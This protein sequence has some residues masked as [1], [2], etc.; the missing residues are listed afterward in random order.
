MGVGLT[1]LLRADQHLP[2]FIA[3]FAVDVIFI[4][5]Q[6]ANLLRLGLIASVCMDMA[7]GFCQRAGQLPPVL[8]ACVGMG[9]LPCHGLPPFRCHTF[10]SVKCILDC[11]SL[12]YFDRI[13]KFL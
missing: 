9:I 2:G 6:R 4:L 8:I 3:R 7:L 12:N 1:F 5:L 10:K 11:I 13:V